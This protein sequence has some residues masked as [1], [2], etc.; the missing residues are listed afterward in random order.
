MTEAFIKG[1][2]LAF[3][4]V[5][6]LGPQN[7]F[8]F[9]QSTLQTKYR[10]VLPVVIVSALCDA[11]LILL[12]VLGLDIFLGNFQMQLILSLVGAS[13]LSFLGYKM[14]KASQYTLASACYNQMS[15][16]KQVAFT[17]SVSLFNPHA[18]MDV[19]L[20]IGTVSLCYVGIEK[21]MFTAACILT[22]I[23]WFICLSLAGFYIK[24]LRNGQSI[25]ML[26]N[27]ISAI[28]MW[29]IAAQIFVESYFI[30]CNKTNLNIG[31][32][33]WVH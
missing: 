22:D 25:T 21:H 24:K 10:S 18:I 30:V 5:I 7:A 4:L 15:I 14:W 12:A 19:F 27:K 9:N 32:N 2:L 16:M 20:V 23:M 17:L 31:V 26:F 6:P 29:Y 11:C 13:F 33:L 3:G 1:V 8:I 28:I